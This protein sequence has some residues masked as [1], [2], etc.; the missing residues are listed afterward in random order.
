MIFA[1]CLLY[2]RQGDKWLGSDFAVGISF[3]FL[4]HGIV[5]LQ[6]PL[7]EFGMRLAQ[8]L[9]GFSYSLYVLHFPFL[10]FLRATLLPTSRWE[11][12]AHTVLYAGFFAFLTLVY[13]FGVSR[14]TEYNTGTIRKWVRNRLNFRGVAPAPALEVERT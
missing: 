2:S 7:G 8:S 6:F 1:L 9:A 5:Q 14:L 4:L 10:V 13:A 12:G 11:A 3:A